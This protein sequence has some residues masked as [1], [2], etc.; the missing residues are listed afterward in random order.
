M[1][2]CLYLN[3]L[4]AARANST[5]VGKM[6]PDASCK[7]HSAL[8][9]LKSTYHDAWKSELTR[10]LHDGDIPLAV[11][12]AL[13]STHGWKALAEGVYDLP[14]LVQDPNSGLEVLIPRAVRRGEDL[15][16]Y[17]TWLHTLSRLLTACTL[18]RYRL[19]TSNPDKHIQSLW[20]D[21][22]NYLP[23]SELV[24]F[25][26]AIERIQ[27]AD[28]ERATRKAQRSSRGDGAEADANDDAEN[29]GRVHGG[30]ENQEGA[31]LTQN[32]TTDRLRSLGAW[33]VA[34]FQKVR[35]FL[36]RP[37]HVVV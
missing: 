33:V 6:F 28:A 29:A 21:A 26:E 10:R 3:A 7:L 34:P 31:E 25:D 15:N 4:C 17:D 35:P 5:L 2:C 37:V 16:W 13:K 1:H 11:A 27:K 30:L 32:E 12:L 19:F 23:V 22:P 8:L 18:I 20:V 14:A 36:G 9:S 24:S